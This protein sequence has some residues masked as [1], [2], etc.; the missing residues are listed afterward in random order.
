MYKK[1]FLVCLLLCL[2]F[3][4][5]SDLFS[6]CNPHKIA[7]KYKDNLG[8]YK[9]DSYAYN[10][11][12]FTDKPQTIEVIFSAYSGMTYKLV[13]GT[14]LF[15]ENVKVNIYDKSQRVR[16]R[17]KLYDNNA[18]IDN[19]FWEQE[20]VK[21][22]TYY[23][24]YDIPAKGSSKSDDGCMVIIIGFKNVTPGHDVKRRDASN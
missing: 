5:E 8:D 4:E 9:Y 15:D 17:K 19:M 18:G 20:L 21:P 7:R 11:V 12:Q 3:L 24:D 14:S 13:F 2:P 22:G 1:L 6:Q 16:N 10:V 23:I